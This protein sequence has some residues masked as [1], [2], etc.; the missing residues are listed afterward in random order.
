MVILNTIF[1]EY[2]LS[3]SRKP[4]SKIRR[5][6][7]TED[8]EDREKWKSRTRVAELK[9]LRKRK[10]KSRSYFGRFSNTVFIQD[11]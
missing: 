5:I 8:V 11:G 7:D 1:D 10:S 6:E 4:M 9:R 3:K 2:R